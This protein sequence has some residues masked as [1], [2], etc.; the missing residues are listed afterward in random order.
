MESQSA[1]ST[2]ASAMVVAGPKRKQIRNDHEKRARIERGKQMAIRKAQC[3]EVGVPYTK[4]ISMAT[5]TA[6]MTEQARKASRPTERLEFKADMASVQEE[7][8]NRIA[9]RVIE[10]FKQVMGPPSD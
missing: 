1:S 5:A 3:E 7:S 10:G 6:Q 2:A 4:F 9:K 8:E